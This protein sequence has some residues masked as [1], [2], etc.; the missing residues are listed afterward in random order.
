MKTL[1]KKSKKVKKEVSWKMEWLANG[2]DPTAAYQEIEKIE[3]ETGEITKE[4]V[5]ISAKNPDSALHNAIEWHW[6]DNSKAAYKW[7]LSQAAKLINNFQIVIVSNG[8]KKTVANYEIVTT[9]DDKKVYKNIE[10][11]TLDEKKEVQLRTKKELIYLKEK[12]EV[13]T[14]KNFLAASVKIHEAVEYLS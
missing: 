6:G 13:Y 4:A 9:P 10:T 2:A 8:E 12:L 5:Y 11:L 3:E 14:D 7:R 1:V